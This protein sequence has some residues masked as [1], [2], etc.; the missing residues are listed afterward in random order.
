LYIAQAVWQLPELEAWFQLHMA[1]P[2]HEAW[3]EYWKAQ[4]LRHAL[5]LGLYSHWY[6]LGQYVWLRWLHATWHCE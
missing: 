1:S 5:V 4:L 6:Q 3:S 2:S